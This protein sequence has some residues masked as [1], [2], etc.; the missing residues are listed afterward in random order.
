MS[1][2][3]IQKVK[4][5][6]AVVKYSTQEHKTNDELITTFECGINSIERDFNS[7]LNEYN[8]RRNEEKNVA[9]RMIIQ[10]FNSEDNL[11]AEQVHQ[12]GVEY[13]NNYLKGNH[14]Y[15]VIT[16][17]E[18]ENLHNHIIFNDINFN[19]LKMFDTKRINSLHNLR[20]ENDKISKK[21]GL[22][23][24]EKGA[25]GRGKYLSFNE[26]V[27]RSKNKS[28]KQKL[29]EVIDKNIQQS[30]SYDDFLE[31]MNKDGYASKDGKYLSFQI[32]EKNQSVRT[33]SLGFNY[34]KESIKY[35]I[36]H[37]E[38]EP[39]K[40]NVINRKWINKKEQKF[41]EN[42]GLYKW[43][44]KQN[45]NYLNELNKQMYETN[46][47][48]SQLESIQKESQKLVNNFEDHLN[49]LD[50]E[51]LKLER[52]EDSFQD[53]S[54]SYNMIIDYKKSVDK[55]KFKKENYSKFKKYDVAKKNLHYLEKNYKITD[56][57]S[58]KYKVSQLH[59]ERDMFYGAIGAERALEGPNKQRE[60]QLEQKPT[61]KKEK[62]NNLEL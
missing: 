27:V 29:E 40:V 13:A 47:P 45:I 8:L 25:K 38:Y 62:N 7:V 50:N 14:Q 19:E 30:A 17:T 37:K 31:L 51:I 55:A 54:D 9:A 15:A 16:H 39:L 33:K 6:K 44:T 41:K 21:Y 28:F 32:P 35:R 57:E 48:I 3:K 12:F 23:I 58:L 26:Y 53:Y 36:E 56:I 5:L 24:I 46:M 34:F 2:V 49:K 42:K 11:T 61:N 20:E 52:M 22:S 1:I 60:T 59:K 10:S 18:T 43:A 4:D